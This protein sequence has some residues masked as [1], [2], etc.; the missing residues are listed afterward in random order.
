MKTRRVRGRAR[1]PRGSGVMP[2]LRGCACAA[3][4]FANDF[5]GHDPYLQGADEDDEG[6]DAEDYVARPTDAYLM[7]A[8]AS[9]DHSVLEVY[10]YDEK[11]G[12]LFGACHGFKL[13]SLPFCELC[14]DARA[15]CPLAAA[16]L[17]P[18]S[19]SRHHAACLPA[20]P[21]MDGHR[22]SC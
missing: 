18:C 2:A 5:V 17:N 19:A 20:V 22:T 9:E 7:V 21:G 1:V 6:S 12:N 10:C 4:S 16:V 3:L 13:E 15:A 8:Q 14:A 11:T